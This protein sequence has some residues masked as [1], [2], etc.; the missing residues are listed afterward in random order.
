MKKVMTYLLGVAC[1]VAL[2]AGAAAQ[3]ESV[4]GSID[5]KPGSFPNSIAPFGRG[6]I[7][8]AILTTE[9]FDALTVDADSVLFGPA[10]AE[11]R[12]KLA[13][14]GDVDDDGDLDLVLHFRTQDTGIALGDI[15]AC[16]IGQTYDGVPIMGCDAVWTVPPE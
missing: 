3:P 9:D 1:A 13:H 7:P 14:V 10:E 4:F 12:H 16:L 5:I 6:V 8:V 11:K 2:S 15:E